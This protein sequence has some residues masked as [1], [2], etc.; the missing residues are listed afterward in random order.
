M[1]IT[2]I[3]ELTLSITENVRELLRVSMKTS[4]HHIALVALGVIPEMNLD[5][6]LYT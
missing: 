4:G 3:T 1:N 2:V 6:I 5:V